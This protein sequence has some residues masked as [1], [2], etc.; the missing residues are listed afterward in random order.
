MPDILVK[1]YL[2]L[3]KKLMSLVTDLTVILSPLAFMCLL[4]YDYFIFVLEKLPSYKLIVRADVQNINKNLDNQLKYMT[5]VI[6][7]AEIC[8][9]EWSCL[10]YRE[11]SSFQQAVSEVSG[12]LHCDSNIKTKTETYAANLIVMKYTLFLQ[13]KFL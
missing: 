8:G 2:T 11:E 6:A 1:M 10:L 5:L 12:G 7:H 9:R 13:E 3:K 4:C